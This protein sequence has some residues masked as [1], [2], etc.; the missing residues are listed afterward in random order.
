MR[1]HSH[2]DVWAWFLIVWKSSLV[3][4]NCFWVSVNVNSTLAFQLDIIQSPA[5]PAKPL[6]PCLNQ[7]V[8]NRAQAKSEK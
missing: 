5:H 8:F 4:T 7:G 1:L 2:K 6:T 3:T